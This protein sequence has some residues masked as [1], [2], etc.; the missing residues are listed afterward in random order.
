MLL[1]WPWHTAA[2]GARSTTLA[3]PRMLKTFTLAAHSTLPVEVEGFLP[4]TKAKPF[5]SRK[6]HH[7]TFACFFCAKHQQ[8]LLSVAAGC[9]AGSPSGGLCHLGQPTE[10]RSEERAGCRAEEELWEKKQAEGVESKKTS[11]LLSLAGGLQPCAHDGLS[12]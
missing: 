2:F 1:G 7:R 9:P 8:P 4:S 3:S 12:P 10:G 11:P 6:T 5:S